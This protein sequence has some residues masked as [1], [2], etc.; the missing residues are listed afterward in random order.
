MLPDASRHMPEGPLNPAE[1]PIPSS[2]AGV[3]EPASVLT[4][5]DGVI[6]LTLL[7]PKS[8]T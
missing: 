3:P 2:E 1:T 8:A 7:F 6:F 4:I 5:P